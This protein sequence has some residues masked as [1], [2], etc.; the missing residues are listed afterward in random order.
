MNVKLTEVI[1]DI[2]GVTGR[3]IIDAILAGQRDPQQLAALRHEKCHNDE[4]TIALALQGNWRDEH[5][6]ALRQAVELY[7]FYHQK[8]A[9]LDRQIKSYVQTL[10]DKS[11]G[12]IIDRSRPRSR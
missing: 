5:L 2:T 4:A 10:P 6:F 1:S 12:E 9:E 11:G 3:N 8:L 7:R